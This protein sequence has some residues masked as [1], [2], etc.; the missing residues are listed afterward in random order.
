MAWGSF[1]VDTQP[2][3]LYIQPTRKLVSINPYQSGKIVD[4]LGE[5]GSIQPC[6]WKGVNFDEI[7]TL[8]ESRFNTETVENDRRPGGKNMETGLNKAKNSHL[9]LMAFVFMVSMVAWPLS[10][11]SAAEKK[12]PSRPIQVVIGFQPGDTDNLLRPFIEK[13]P[14]YLGEPLT[15]VYKPGA[16]GSLGASFVAA[17]KPDGYTL[18]GTSQ[19]SICAVPLMQKNLDYNWESFSPVSCLL[20]VPYLFAVKADARW[21]NIRELV[22]EAKKG[23]Q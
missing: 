11:A 1:P 14:E 2:P 5:G 6:A 17:T 12:F 16:A 7:C 21:T 3:F 8:E 19:S 22:A 23:A 20:K 18:L 4:L 9:G 10:G 15:F 13:M